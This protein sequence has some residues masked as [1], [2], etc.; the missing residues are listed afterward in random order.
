MN[1]VGFI[2]DYGKFLRNKTWAARS[3]T[4]LTATRGH[5]A[6]R[7]DS[8]LHGAIAPT[9][10]SIKYEILHRSIEKSLKA[11]WGV[12]CSLIRFDEVSTVPVTPDDTLPTYR[13]VD[14]PPLPRPLS[15]TRR[16]I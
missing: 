14:R 6:R 3:S 15:R 8:G 10:R 5:R 7:P 1:S 4:V 9:P 16:H 11:L 12:Y 13:P 2:F